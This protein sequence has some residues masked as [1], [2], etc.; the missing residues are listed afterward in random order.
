MKEHH[1]DR[2]SY[3]RKTNWGLLKIQ[4]LSPLLRWQE[5]RQHAGRYGA[6]EVESSMSSI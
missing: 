3:K 1:D 2:N 6:E 4:R 5:A